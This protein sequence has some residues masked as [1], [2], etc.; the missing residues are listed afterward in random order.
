MLAGAFADLTGNYRVGFTLLA[1]L[2]GLGTMFF[3]L[4][5]PPVKPDAPSA[6]T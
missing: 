6:D 4:A 5:H 1:G 3:L 2:A